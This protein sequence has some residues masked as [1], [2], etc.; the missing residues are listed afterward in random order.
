M[1]RTRKKPP[2]RVDDRARLE[3]VDTAV[4]AP[5]KPA[6]ARRRASDGAA[7]TG[8]VV[9]EL[10]G[11]E[12]EVP[13][14]AVLGREGSHPRE[15]RFDY[16]PA[17]VEPIERGRRKKVRAV[18]PRSIR[19][20][21]DDPKSAAKAFYDENEAF[22][23][24]IRDPH[25]G[26]REWLGEVGTP[27]RD[28]ARVL[29]KVG[30]PSIRAALALVFGRARGRRWDAV[31][32][33]DVEGLA[34]ALEP[35]Y[36][37]PGDGTG[38]RG[39]YWRPVVGD[40]TAEQ[41]EAMAPDQRAAARDWEAHEEIREG[42]ATARELYERRKACI[43]PAAAE[44]IERRLAVLE[45]WR[46]DP[47]A[48]PGY[49]CARD[50][51]TDGMTC[52]FPALHGEIAAIRSACEDGYDPDWSTDLSRD[53]AEGFPDTSRGPADPRL[54]VIEEPTSPADVVPCVSTELGRPLGAPPN[55]VRAQRIVAGILYRYELRTC[56][57][58]PRAPKAAVEL[59]NGRTR[60]A[61]GGRD[62]CHCYEDFPVNAHGPYWYAY[63]PDAHGGYCRAIYV[64]KTF[65][66]IG[67]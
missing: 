5:V 4:G 54:E 35:Y 39:L 20:T 8:R 10:E 26:L 30:A 3:F 60:K 13:P 38:R 36:E 37:A 18:K 45:R 51:R 32:W 48:I 22:F 6:P 40:A 64:G 46:D 52:D 44:V 56:G 59:K 61:K 49:A 29:E 66:E 21:F 31:E 65:K 34:A 15:Q 14:A 42:V 28:R 57:F 9:A 2:P 25:D 47:A 11:E 12:V 53:A 67:P 16:D 19:A 7:P 17:G 58:K 63:P 41:L 55:A 27:P 50:P 62:G 1:S 23:D 43:P 24:N 33:R